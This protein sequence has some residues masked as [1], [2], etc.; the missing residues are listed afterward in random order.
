MLCA[1]NRRNQL[2][3]REKDGTTDAS[4]G[5]EGTQNKPR[6]SFS[7]PNL[8]THIINFV[9]AD[10]QVRQNKCQYCSY[11]ITSQSINV[12][13]CPEFRSLLLLM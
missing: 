13:E 5:H 9:V 3:G 1:S 12:I 7:R 4:I 11:F 2:P 10:D 6:P 8:L